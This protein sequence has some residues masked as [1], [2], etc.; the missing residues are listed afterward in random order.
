MRCPK[1]G[2][3]H[4][5]VMNCRERKTGDYVYRMRECQKCGYRFPTYETTDY[6]PGLYSKL[7][8]IKKIVE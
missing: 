8:K 3:S 2:S 4:S 6:L 7:E 5:L 1:C